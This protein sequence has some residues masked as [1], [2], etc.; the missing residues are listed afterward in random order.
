MAQKEVKTRWAKGRKKGMRLHR[1]CVRLRACLLFC[2]SV[3]A[4]SLRGSNLDSCPHSPSPPENLPRIA[5]L[6]ASLALD[7]SSPEPK[8]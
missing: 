4:A 5:F 7:H 3:G 2:L 1:V 8:P 6:A